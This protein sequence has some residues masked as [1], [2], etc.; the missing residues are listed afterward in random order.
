MT[1]TVFPVILSGGAGS[2]LWPVSR[3][4]HPKQLTA[5]L[6]EHTLLQ[7]TARRLGSL[8]GDAVR[9]PIVV[10]NEAHRFL[11]TE[12][13]EAVGV[14]PSAIVLEPAGRNTAPAIAAAA[15]EALGRVDG[16]EEPILLVLPA[17]H[18]IRDEARFAGAVR[19]AVREAQRGTIALLGV[20]PTYAETGYGYIIAGGPAGLGSEARVVERFVEKPAVAVAAEWIEAGSCYWNSGMFVFGAERYLRELGIHAPAVLE[21]ATGAHERAA[22]DLGFLRLDAECFTRSPAVSVDHAVMEHA[23]DAV[24]VPLDAGW[25]DVGSWAS[26]AELFAE[27]ESGNAAE[28]D[29]IFHGARN[30]FVRAEDRMVAAVGVDDLVVVDTPDAVLVAAKRSTQD[31]KRVVERLEAAGRDEHRTHR[32]VYRPWGSYDAVRAGEG[33][34][35]K[36]I[37]VRP[38]G[39]LSLQAHRHRAEH[40]VVVRGV[41]RVTR[42]EETFTLEANQSTYIPKSVRHRLE[43]PGSAP[44]EIIEVQTGGYLE[45]DDIER[46]DDAYG[47]VDG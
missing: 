36:H 43:N 14:A 42:G 40:W 27:D 3:E 10:A 38:G 41:A 13:L 44:L 39:R 31:V 1:P 26:L 7:A 46:F 33:F 37:V 8:A 28:G 11:V 9:A 47:R 2:R 23:A 18:V 22:P 19:H 6:D 17:D 29:V 45:E 5:L 12:Q 30:T 25:S 35:V 21:A 15:L 24:V 4:L 16:E 20:V 32:K 34:K